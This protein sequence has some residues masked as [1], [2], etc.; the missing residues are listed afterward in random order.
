MTA[1]RRQRKEL[2]YVY[3]LTDVARPAPF[4]SGKRKLQ[5]LEVKGVSAI[6]E[7]VRAR[8]PVT[9]ETLR[10]QHA[11]VARLARRFEALLPVRFGAVFAPHDL[12]ARMESDHEVI[13]RALER[14]RGRVQMTI[15]LHGAPARPLPREA[16]GTAWLIARIERDRLLRRTAAQVRRAVSLFVDAE[17]IDPGKG[18]LQGT[19]YHLVKSQHVE[20][21]TS[22]ITAVAPALA[23]IRVTITGP[24]PV[25]AFAPELGRGRSRGSRGRGSRGRGTHGSRGR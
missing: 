12:A 7:A 5:A 2:Y 14:V 6:V 8:R 23:P 13:R 24:W 15:R 9:E 16:S 10:A 11:T 1:D 18:D 3:A 22:A 17:R 25:F 19:V 4:T 21:Y 20:P